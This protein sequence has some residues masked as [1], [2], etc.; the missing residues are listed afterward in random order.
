MKRRLAELP[1]HTGHAPPWLFERM[2]RLAG[3]VTMAVVDAYGPAEMLRRLAEPWWFQ[4]LGCAIGMDWHSSG[5][6]TITCGALKQAYRHFGD[7]LG[8]HVA[9]GKGATSRQTPLEIART[10]D[11]LALTAGD[12][13]VFA[14]K[15]SAKVDSAGL[16]DGYDL[17]HPPKNCQ[18]RRAAQARGNR[19]TSQGER[20]RRAGRTGGYRRPVAYRPARVA[21]PGSGEAGAGGVI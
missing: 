1:L 18:D 16:Q 8:L 11:R 7:D 15:M 10:A 9:G 14:S 19:V 20:P 2:W 21:G 12:R 5:I 13:L 6:T 3:A 4:A 17:Y